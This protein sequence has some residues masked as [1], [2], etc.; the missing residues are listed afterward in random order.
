MIPFGVD[1]S[2]TTFKI[3]GSTIQSIQASKANAF[4]IWSLVGTIIIDKT[5]PELTKKYHKKR[6]VMFKK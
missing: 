1:M 2:A 6:L 5:F 4:P 3:K